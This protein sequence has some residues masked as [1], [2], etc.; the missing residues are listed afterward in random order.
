MLN[1]NCE[2]FYMQ[3]LCH[4][5]NKI[6][7]LNPW[8]SINYFDFFLMSYC[9]DTGTV[10][11][12]LNLENYSTMSDSGNSFPMKTIWIHI[13]DKNKKLTDKMEAYC[14]AYTAKNNIPEKYS[15]EYSKRQNRHVL[16]RYTPFF[17]DMSLEYPQ[18]LSFEAVE[19]MYYIL[20]NSYRVFISKKITD[21]Q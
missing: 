18:P 16:N 8:R 17:I 6:L 10:E 19:K 3:K 9:R 2:E 21:S 14:C 20:E 7:L 1:F 12:I 11:Y 15:R 5:A 13:I 4:T